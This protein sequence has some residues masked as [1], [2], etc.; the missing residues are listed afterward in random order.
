MA[1]TEVQQFS[2]PDDALREI[3]RLTEISEEHGDYVRRVINNTLNGVTY[4]LMRLPSDFRRLLSRTARLC[5]DLRSAL[6]ELRRRKELPEWC[7]NE[8][9][10]L[11]GCPA[12]ERYLRVP[13]QEYPLV[14][15]SKDDARLD[16]L[17]DEFLDDLARACIHYGQRPKRKPHPSIQ[18]SALS[19]DE[20]I[21]SLHFIAERCGG[22]LAP[23]RDSKGKCRGPLP[24]V[25]KILH[26]VAPEIV[27][28][29][30][31]YST[32]RRL[33][34]ERSKEKIPKLIVSNRPPERR[35]QK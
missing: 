35:L 12:V 22:K 15:R 9:T 3:L 26:D 24:A 23:W 20:L 4:D 10:L 17:L 29:V 2:L 7:W 6:S 30:P 14:P 32:L 1:E 25:L 27:P 13:K 28:P 5:E 18:H 21:R 19:A 16:G 11:R 31:P 8:K 34:K 33:F